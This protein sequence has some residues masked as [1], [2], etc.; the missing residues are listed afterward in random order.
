[1]SAAPHNSSSN[2]PRWQQELAEAVRDPAE[3]LQ[4]LDLDAGL[5]PA[6]RKAAAQFPLRVPR[7][8]V[9]RMQRGD[10]NDPLLRQ[11]LPLAAEL[12]PA[13]GYLS[14][15]V[16]DLQAM[17]PGGILH[18]YHGRVLLV[19]TGAC[20][21]HCRYCFRRHFPYAE[22]N[23]AAD[24]W[25]AALDYIRSRPEISE[26]ILSGGDPL[27]LND[28]RLAE[29]ARALAEIPHLRRLRL[30]SRLPIVLP[31]RIDASL[32]DWFTGT[33]LTPVLVMHANHP[34]ELD[35]EVAAAT[36]RLR[37]HGVVLLNQT[38]LLAGVNDSAET[39]IELSE[40]LFTLGVQ[41]YYLHA[42]DRVQGAGHFESD[43]VLRTLMP[44]LRARLPGYLVPQ[45][46]REEAGQPNKTP[47]PY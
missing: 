45:P 3:L 36:A 14:D 22:A 35:A 32:L 44:L 38:V 40:R 8:F 29:L 5:L 46:V 42:L 25:T 37:Q 26:V 24:H 18:K 9:A 16:G 2:T 20:A 43:A 1:M 27:V 47:L 17:Q 21:I 41:P 23:A 13:P 31:S 12:E 11:V 30:H 28:R 15:P 19:A 7:G 10:P 33:R 6:A 34:R 4:L 39:L